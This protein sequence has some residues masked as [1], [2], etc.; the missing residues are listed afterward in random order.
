M[1]IIEK[2]EIKYFRSFADKKV[3]IDNLGDLNI[4]SGSNDSGKSNILRGINLFFNNETSPGI[5]FN[6][7]DDL[8]KLQRNRS[9]E[10]VTKKRAGGK[11]EAR[12]KDLFIDVKIHFLLPSD[13]GGMLPK[14]FFVSRRWTKTKSTPPYQ[15]SN[16]ETRYKKEKGVLTTNQK[17][18]LLGQ[19]TQFLNKIEFRYVP[20]IKDRGF[21]R[22]LY[23]ELQGKLLEKEISEIKSESRKLQDV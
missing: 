2:V 17:N 9:D 6:V 1:K 4:F 5:R 22:H 3:E 13:F 7:D 10:R 19:L 18:A 12:Q 21:F 20:A 11:T 14:I 15:E 23:K 8:S 16:V